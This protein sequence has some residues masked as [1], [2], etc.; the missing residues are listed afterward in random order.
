MENIL[1]DENF[2]PKIADF[3]YDTYNTGKLIDPAGIPGYAAPEI[4]ENKL[5]DGYQA[6]IF[7]LGVILYKLYNGNK[8]FKESSKK[9]HFYQYIMDEDYKNYWKKITPGLKGIKDFENFKDLYNKM[10]SYNPKK[11]PTIIEIL[12]SE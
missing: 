11:R 1:L 5:Y 12:K 9:D 2:T 6:D 7:S 3:G 10:I 4:C 8:P